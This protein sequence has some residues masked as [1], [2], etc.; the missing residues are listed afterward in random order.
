MGKSCTDFILS[1]VLI[2]N[3]KTYQQNLFLQ[4]KLDYTLE[5]KALFWNE[6]I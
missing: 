5:D 6:K 3:L 2:L 1:L 4:D